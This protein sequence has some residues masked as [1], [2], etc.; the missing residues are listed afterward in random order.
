MKK[1]FLFVVALI[2]VVAGF[3]A[4]SSTEVVESLASEP[5]SSSEV[6][7]DDISSKEVSEEA[8]S[9]EVAEGYS[10]D[11]VMKLVDELTAKYQYNNPEHIKALVVAAN[12]DYICSEDLD[13]I[14]TTYGYTIEDMATL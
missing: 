8:S 6:A 14:L 12:L 13:T 1:N 4:C 9:E 7:S 3:M 2:V 10:A 11:E 5:A